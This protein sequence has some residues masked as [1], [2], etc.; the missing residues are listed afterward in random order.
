MALAIG[1]KVL[2]EVVS[3]DLLC[4]VV[5]IG[6]RFIRIQLPDGQYR[7]VLPRSVLPITDIEGQMSGPHASEADSN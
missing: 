6:T 4:T 7:T 5:K 2:Y 3:G 1:D